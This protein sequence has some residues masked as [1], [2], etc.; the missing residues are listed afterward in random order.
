M[1]AIFEE[2]ESRHLS[3]MLRSDR[4]KKTYSYDGKYVDE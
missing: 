4:P 3:V 1:D 2:R